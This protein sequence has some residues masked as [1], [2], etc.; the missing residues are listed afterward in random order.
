M[1]KYRIGDLVRIVVETRKNGRR[2]IVLDIPAPNS[3]LIT[4]AFQ[5]VAKNELT[6]TYK[7]IIDDDMIGWIISQFHIDHEN[8]PKVF[9]GKRFYDIPESI[10]L[11]EA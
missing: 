2:Y 8:I 9:N 6:Q 3:K 7:I 4:A 10:I 5:I 11:G 1:M